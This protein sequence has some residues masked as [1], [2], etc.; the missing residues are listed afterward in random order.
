MKIIRF[1]DADQI[2]RYGRLADGGAVRLLEGEVYG[3]LRDAHRAVEV[4]KLLAPVAPTAIYCIGLNYIRHAQEGGL[5]VPEFP[6]VFMESP[7]ALQHPGDPIQLP[8]RLRSD[9]V[10]YECELA[11]VI[12]KPCKNATQENALDYVLGYTCANDVSARDWQGK[13]G[14]GQ[15]CRGKTFDTFAPLGPCLVTT[16][17]IKNPNALAIRTTLNESVVQ[18]WNTADMI[19]SVRRLIEFLSGSTT[20]PAGTVILTGTPHGIGAARKPPIFL[21]PGDTVTIEI[22]G[23]G[24]LTN[25]VVEEE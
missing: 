8:R 23:I 4:K 12:G 15:W 25:P 10:D 6:V 3:A 2:I 20:L 24:K 17:E 9:E 5:Q 22:E 7:A 13:W 19:F 14:G 1:L 11:V 18:D 16:D 21:K